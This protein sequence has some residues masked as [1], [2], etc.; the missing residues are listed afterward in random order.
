MRNELT[1]IE[2]KVKPLRNIEIY[3]WRKHQKKT[4]WFIANLYNLHYSRINQITNSVE[5]RFKR[6]KS[7]NEKEI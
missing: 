4:L 3:C 2:T 7:L 6:Y 5:R 1:T